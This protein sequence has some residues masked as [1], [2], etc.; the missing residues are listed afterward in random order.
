MGLGEGLGAKR[1]PWAA[2]P[3]LRSLTQTA[4]RTRRDVP[5]KLSD[6]QTFVSSCFTG[7]T[8]HTWETGSWLSLNPVPKV[9]AEEAPPSRAQQEF[10]LMRNRDRGAPLLLPSVTYAGRPR[11]S[12]TGEARRADIPAKHPP[13]A[14]PGSS[15]SR[16]STLNL[17]L[18]H[19]ISP[20]SLCILLFSV[21]T[22]FTSQ[23]EHQ[24]LP[25]CLGICVQRCWAQNRRS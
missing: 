21:A 1:V 3:R 16:T 13:R 25:L 17:T 8:P 7:S 2:G 12:S 4:Q 22:D 18:L 20:L 6:L 19:P 11:V 15:R 10:W 9:G 23:T 14:L 5:G 24:H